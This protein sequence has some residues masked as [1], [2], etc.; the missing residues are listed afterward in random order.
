MQ[1]CEKVRV[2]H[3]RR[4]FYATLGSLPLI[5]LLKW[6][7]VLGAETPAAPTVMDAGAVY[8]ARCA[9]CHGADMSGEG[10]PALK[11]LNF[12]EKWLATGPEALKDYIQQRMPPGAPQPLDE[13]TALQVAQYIRTANGI[14]EG[15][16]ADAVP[17]VPAAAAFS[18]PISA[19]ANARLRAVA[20]RLSSVTDAMLQ[21]PPKE[22]WLIWRGDLGQSGYSQIAQ[23]NSSNAAKLRIVWAKTLGGGANG[24]APLA[25]DGVIFLHGGGHITAID[26][27]SG[28]TIW[29]LEDTTPSRG[30]SQPRGIALYGNALYA[31]TVDNHTMAVDARTGK[32]LWKISLSGPGMLSAP[33][34]AVNGRVFQ[35]MAFCGSKAAR[36]FMAALDA[37]T[38]A[39]LWRSYTI[40]T[41]REPGAKSWR[42][43]PEAGWSGAGIWSGYSYDAAADQL[44]FGTGNTY[45]VS[46]LLSADP[47]KPPAA[48]YT[49][50]TLKLDAR[51]G[52]LVWYFQHVPGDV[53]DEDWAFENTIVRDPRKGN[54]RVVLSM[55]KLG[56]L[57]ALDFN[58]GRYLW[59]VDMGLQD[60]VTR[61]DPV[62]GVKSIDADKIPSIG[63]TA[64]ACPFAGGVRNWTAT[65]YDPEKAM[66]FIPMTDTCMEIKVDSSTAYGSAWV[67]VPRPGSDHNY[68]RLAAIDLRT[69]KPAWTVRRRAPAASA[70]LATAGGIL[71]E[72]SRDRWFRALDSA[73]G[74]V[75]WQVRLSDTP[76]SFPITYMVNGKQYVAVVSGGG[77]FLD[78][79]YNRLTPEIEPSIGRPTLWVFALAE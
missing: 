22:D 35:G 39:E 43:V 6:G 75:L 65:A 61:I 12:K 13:K 32:L 11:G 40:P 28:D 76:N 49:N 34:L 21:A 60:I 56:I 46:S 50:S 29:S 26:A 64:R 45:A 37:G 31:S 77:T 8:A 72:G 10:A 14:G 54:S 23:I 42:G 79:L 53:W 2:F 70:V 74:K 68:G 67:V 48:L 62:T 20:S 9:S 15:A 59:S 52:K 57:D 19:A 47:R 78:G 27:A 16:T 41:T 73:T 38:G 3:N 51:T 69:G 71:F 18:D 7:A 33:P 63:K 25:H 58:T 17:A 1:S 5:S 30:V 55:G 66:L 36:C 44:V 24:I 4:R